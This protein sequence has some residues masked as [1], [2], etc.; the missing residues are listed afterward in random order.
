MRAVLVLIVGI[1]ALMRPAMAADLMSADAARAAAE[2]GQIVLVDI[3]T[4][5]EWQATGVGDLTVP[6]DMRAPGFIREIMAL[7][8]EDP[9]RPVAL[10]C[11]TGGRSAYVTT[12]LEQRGVTGLINVGEGMMGSKH[13]PGWLARGLPVRQP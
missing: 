4:P 11:A 6:L 1:L 13:G 7:R 10:I 12:A 8:A 5:E 3:R 9:N 2:Q